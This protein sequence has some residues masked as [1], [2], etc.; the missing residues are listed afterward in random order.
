M[1][2]SSSKAPEPVAPGLNPVDVAVTELV[3]VADLYKRMSD[4]CWKKCVPSVKDAHLGTGEQSCIDR[5]V[6]KYFGVH[7]M[8]GERIQSAFHEAE[9]SPGSS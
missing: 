2:K 8:V 7:E 1:F 6:N 4:I 3:A 9:A 5:C